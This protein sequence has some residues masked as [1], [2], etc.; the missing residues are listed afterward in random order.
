MSHS[1]AR[2]IRAALTATILAI[3]PATLVAQ[4][5]IV[6]QQKMTFN[7]AGVTN[8]DL[9]Q[10]ISILGADRAKTVTVGKMKVVILSVDASGTEITRLDEGQ[11]MKLND[12]KKTYTV[13][14]IAEMRADLAKQQKDAEKSAASG[15]EKD[16]IR[17]YPVLDEARRTGE[18]KTIN[19]FNTEQVSIKITVMGEDQKT[20]KTAPYMH[21]ITDMWIDPS[22]RD[23][24]RV[25]M[26]YAMAQQQALGVD[27]AMAAN[28][29]AKWMK[30]INAEM[31][32]L[33][34]YPIRSVMTFEAEV[35]SASA[36]NKDNNAGA[37]GNPMAALG[38]MFGKKKSEEPA[39][40]GSGSGRP[41]LFTA[42][43]EVQ[44]ITSTPPAGSEF[45]VPV[46][47][48]KK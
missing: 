47:Y 33:E 28:P 48:V 17:Y 5:G 19:G 18:R 3:A 42:T 25:S 22:Q 21:L 40:A 1:S 20:K 14:T 29:Y 45:E 36:A 7:V 31:A 9:Q 11:V 38:G 10:T 35:D 37:R 15:R 4:S 39:A 46:G 13:K 26:A 27:P 32:K 44:S 23:A 41:V 43:I 6:V 34:G 16:D 8:A 24:G 12:K 30:D 2:R